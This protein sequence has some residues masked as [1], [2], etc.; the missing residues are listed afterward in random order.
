[1]ILTATEIAQK[2]IVSGG[3]PNARM[4]T[5]DATV[6]KILTIHGE[7]A[8]S[9]YLLK[10]RGIAWVISKETFAI[11][12]DVTGLATLKTTWTHKGV[13]A[14]TL[15][16]VD[17]GW[18]GPLATAVVNFSKKSFPIRVGDP[19]FRLL[20]LSHKA[21]QPQPLIRTMAQY[22]NDIEDHTTSYSETFLTIDTL[23][24]E[25]AD[26]IFGLPRIA[27]TFGVAALILAALAIF[28]PIAWTVYSDSKSNSVKIE[29]LEKRVE[30]LE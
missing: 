27:F 16:I 2:G 4:T 9:K 20:F 19:F 22:T 26:K 28:A 30:A 13:L 5:Y 7:F 18:D 24:P 11:P 1:M 3:G 29:A 12:N 8:G 14:L 15:G 6:G 21:T 10:P 25:I 23:V 17:P